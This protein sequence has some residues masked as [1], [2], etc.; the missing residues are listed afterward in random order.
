MMN[1]ITLIC[2]LQAAILIL[3]SPIASAEVIRVPYGVDSSGSGSRT[4]ETSKLGNGCDG[5]SDYPHISTHVPNTVNVTAST[6]CNGVQVTVETT[7][8]RNGWFIFRESVTKKSS[9][10][11]KAVVNVSLPCK[12]KIGEPPIEY[13]VSSFHRESRGATARTSSHRSIQC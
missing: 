6:T 4:F 13:I 1:K 8:S 11:S 12:W 3:V 5:R 9:G 10:L 2:L 7:L